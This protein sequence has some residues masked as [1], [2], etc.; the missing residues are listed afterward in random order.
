M[1]HLDKTN[2]DIIDHIQRVKMT[3]VESR[4]CRF[5]L[6]LWHSSKYHFQYKND[7]S[8]FDFHRNPLSG[9]LVSRINAMMTLKP[10]YL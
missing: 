7:D 3:L 1:H 4:V 8:Q 10:F 9:A 5:S 2:N 6:F